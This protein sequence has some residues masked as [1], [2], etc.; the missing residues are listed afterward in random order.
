VVS[1]RDQPWPPAGPAWETAH[2][3]S[4]NR[5]YRLKFLLPFFGETPVLRLTKPM[6][7]EFRKSRKQ[8]RTGTPIKDATANR[9][10]SVFR[11]ILYWAVDERMLEA[12][13]LARLKMARERRTK[14]QVLS[15]SEEEILLPAASPRLRGMIIAALDTGMRRGE[16]TSQL[17]QDGDLD[18][19]ILY[20]TRSKTPAGEAREVPPTARLSELLVEALGRMS[21]EV[22][23][24]SWHGGP[25]P[26]G[27]P[28]RAARAARKA[29]AES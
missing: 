29:A 22:T 20:V 28:D 21:H 19:G 12:N 4:L 7:E 5:S 13:P 27:E 15:I 11:H 1:V 25:S 8:A 17:W 9:D 18:R 3:Q 16:I 23:H 6:T 2:R 14:R 26:A 10:L 24:L